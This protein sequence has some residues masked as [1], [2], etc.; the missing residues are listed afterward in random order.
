MTRDFSSRS[1]PCGKDVGAD[2]AL[3]WWPAGRNEPA[4]PSAAVRLGRLGSGGSARWGCRLA[5][6]PPG[7]SAGPPPGTPAGRTTVWWPAYPR[8][9]DTSKSTGRSGR[10]KV[11]TRRNMRREERVTVQGPVKEQQPDGMSHRGC[12]F[13]IFGWVWLALYSN[14][15]FSHRKSFPNSVVGESPKSPPPPP[16]PVGK[17]RPGADF[18]KVYIYPPFP[19]Q[20]V[21]ANGPTGASSGFL[22]F[23]D[24]PPP[25]P[26]SPTPTHLPPVC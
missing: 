13:A 2:Q 5:E 21:G 3:A 22:G 15:I 7:T 10:Q 17:Q 8:G 11:A 20:C 9:G 25:P 12:P 6:P 18:K 16:P 26:S 23:L 4:V 14:F 1:Q 24:N 19:G